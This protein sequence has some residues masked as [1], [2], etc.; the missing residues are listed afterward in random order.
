MAEP[1]IS[2]VALV[3]DVSHMYR[4]EVESHPIL[5]LSRDNWTCGSAY[6]FKE[7]GQPFL[8]KLESWVC[9][10]VL[11]YPSYPCHSSLLTWF[12]SSWVAPWQCLHW[13]VYVKCWPLGFFMRWVPH[14][15]F[16]LFEDGHCEVAVHSWSGTFMQCTAVFQCTAFNALGGQVN[17]SG[18]I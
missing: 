4:R 1:G 7:K 15:P 18:R 3:T 12:V 13:S 9:M 2:L 10:C 8:G 6:D 17:Y 16:F 5:F 14:N 11:C